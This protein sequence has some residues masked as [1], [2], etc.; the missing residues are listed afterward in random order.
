[1]MA[2][3]ETVTTPKAA[4]TRRHDAKYSDRVVQCLR[5]ILNDEGSPVEGPVFD[6]FAGTGSRLPNLGRRDISGIELEPE[7]AE[8]SPL[9]SEGDALFREDYP[10]DVRAIVTSPCYGNRMADQYLGPV[11]KDCSGTGFDQIPV[12]STRKPKETVPGYECGRCKGSGR[13][14]SGRY[15]YA[16]SLGRKVS[17]G[18]AA[19]LQWGPKYRRFHS[20]WM[21]LISGL[22]PVG[23]R[24]FVLNMSDHN[25]DNERQYVVDWWI[26]DA[27][28]HGFRFVEAQAVD[29]PR[30]G[31]GQNSSS[32]PESE[33]VIVF[34]LLEREI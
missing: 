20:E 5:S 29:T 12:P 1:M 6:P 30:F 4:D 21:R 15:G 16:I 11:C 9:V 8:M 27:R 17:D 3:M 19:A 23:P 24:R 13:D 18:S 7:W 25:R 34:D 14:G 2:E 10:D 33:M 28:R 22:L 32:K 31:H 26:R